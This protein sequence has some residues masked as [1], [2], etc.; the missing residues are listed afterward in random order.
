M[1]EKHTVFS[2]ILDFSK[3]PMAYQSSTP[4][5]E[6][7]G[8]GSVRARRNKKAPRCGALLWLESSAY[9]L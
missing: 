9:T 7:C 4:P 2:I 1:A 3:E 6:K 5:G 8:L